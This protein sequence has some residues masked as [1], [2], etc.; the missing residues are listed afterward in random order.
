MWGGIDDEPKFHLVHWK[1]VCEPLQN[2][3][4]GIH[5]LD[6]FNKALRR[7]LLRRYGTECESLWKRVVDS[8]CLQTYYMN[9]GPIEVKL[10]LSLS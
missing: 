5:N 6:V 10:S 3:G 1:Q 2:C 8:A 7:K 4:L 9:L